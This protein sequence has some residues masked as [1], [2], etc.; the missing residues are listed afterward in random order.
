V[1]DNKLDQD[2]KLIEAAF[3]EGVITDR[4]RSTEAMRAKER[5]AVRRQE[6]QRSL[7]ILH[8]LRCLEDCEFTRRR[9]AK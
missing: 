4:F 9:L 3:T 5:A 8:K 1:I 2:L 7:A 6:R